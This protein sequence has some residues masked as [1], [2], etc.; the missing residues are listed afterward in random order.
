[1]DKGF[2]DFLRDFISRIRVQIKIFEKGQDIGMKIFQGN[3]QVPNLNLA[4]Q[5]VNL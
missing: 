4:S 5:F 1:M 2:P 3:Q